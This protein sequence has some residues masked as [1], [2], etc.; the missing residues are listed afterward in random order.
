MMTRMAIMT[1]LVG[2]RGPH[3]VDITLPRVI[4]VANTDLLASDTDEVRQ[5]KV[6]AIQT[7]SGTCV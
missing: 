1:A 4:R 3:N 2:K 7:V 6:C 5:G